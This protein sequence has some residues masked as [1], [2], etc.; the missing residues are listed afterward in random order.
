LVAGTFMLRPSHH[1]ETS[2]NW[3]T[4]DVYASCDFGVFRLR[5]GSTSWGAAAPGMPKVEVARLTIVAGERKLFGGPQGVRVAKAMM[6]NEPADPVAV[7]A[8]GATKRRT[9]S[10]SGGLGGV[11][12]TEHSVLSD[13][14]VSPAPA[15]RRRHL[16]AQTPLMWPAGRDMLAQRQAVPGAQA[17]R[18][19]SASR[20]P[21]L[22]NDRRTSP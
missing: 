3:P 4:G 1:E 7:G 14:R 12:S 18:H 19:V 9:L 10:G 22:T 15:Q 21:L 20:S 13:V 16:A 5:S 17:R 11:W 6:A 2:A 8:F